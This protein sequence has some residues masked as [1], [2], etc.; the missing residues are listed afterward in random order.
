MKFNAL[1]S[2]VGGGAGGHGLPTSH[3]Q[4]GDMAPHFFDHSVLSNI[5]VK[6]V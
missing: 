3:F 6:Q 2:G 1:K 4:T 5:A